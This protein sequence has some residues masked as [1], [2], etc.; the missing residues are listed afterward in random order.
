MIFEYTAQ[1]K[2]Q[3]AE[4]EKRYAALLDQKDNELQKHG[5]KKKAY[6]RLLEER[7]ELESERITEHAEFYE[8]AEQARFAA[9]N[10]DVAAIA[11]EARRQVSL[12]IEH[13]IAADLVFNDQSGN[14]IQQLQGEQLTEAKALHLL[15]S[16]DFITRFQK[17]GRP[18]ISSREARTLIY[19]GLFLFTEFLKTAAPKEAAALD[20]YIS[21]Y[22]SMC[23]YIYIYTHKPNVEPEAITDDIRLP[24]P[25]IETYGLMN[26]KVSHQLIAGDF[27]QQD[28]DGQLSFW[29]GV[30]Q[31]PATSKAPV[32]VT[33]AL[34]FEGAQTKLSKRMSGIDNAV[35]NAVATAFYYH[36]RSSS[37]RPFYITPQEIWRLMNGTQDAKKNPS[38]AQMQ[39]VCDSMDKMRFTR[40]YM[41]ISE[42]IKAY[43]LT[44]EDERLKSGAIDTYMLKSDK[45]SFTTE[46]GKTLIGYRVDQ[47][48]ILY[49]YN[50][51]KDHVL[52]VPF[53]LLDT[54][55]TTGNEGSTIEIRNYLLQQ[56]ELMYNGQRDSLRILYETIYKATGLESPEERTRGNTYTNENTRRSALTQEAKRDRE[57]IA[58]ILTAW[59]AKDYITDFCPVKKGRA[60]IGVDI[61]LNTNRKHTTT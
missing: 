56:I 48:P 38:A 27:T 6:A 5:K 37:G 8:R 21:E 20:V 54:S 18:L 58:A 14:I 26:D 35:Y 13:R 25:L 15:Q 19:R 10:G 45:V 32:I 17:E 7:D 31:S 61:T 16:A 1:E 41:D 51:A 39:K 53:D 43:N 12:I 3:L 36:K 23:P 24:L 28:T 4:I 33:M 42:E 11:D 29:A 22:I 2:E 34:T 40:L 46:K 49:T 59:K 44:F 60:F 50:A 52:F 55:Q 57:K 47:E 30:R 9:F